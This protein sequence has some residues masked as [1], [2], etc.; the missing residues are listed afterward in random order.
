MDE[1]ITKRFKKVGT[2][3]NKTVLREQISSDVEA[4]LAAGGKITKI[5]SEQDFNVGSP[6]NVWGIS[7]E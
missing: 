4:Y 3:E 6:C 2:I 5:P 1:S 7:Y